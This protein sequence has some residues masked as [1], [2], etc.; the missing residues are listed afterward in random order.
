MGCVPDRA[1]PAGVSVFDTDDVVRIVGDRVPA[2]PRFNLQHGFRRFAVFGQRVRI[3][4]LRG[5]D[6]V[7]NVGET[8]DENR[9]DRIDSAGEFSIAR[10]GRSHVLGVTVRAD[11]R[12]FAEK[13]AADPFPVFVRNPRRTVPRSPQADTVVEQFRRH[14]R[15]VVDPLGRHRITLQFGSVTAS[16]AVATVA[17]VFI[18]TASRR[19]DQCGQQSR[20]HPF[21]FHSVHDYLKLKV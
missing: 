20:T 13:V 2:I 15:R 11:N 1:D 4:D 7:R 19:S 6:F 21:R 14:G 12:I 5:A 17:A 10:I 9:P 16:A 18:F 3:T 8:V